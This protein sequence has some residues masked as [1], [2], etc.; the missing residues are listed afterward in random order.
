MFGIVSACN[1]CFNS[2]TDLTEFDFRFVL[3]CP[4]LPPLDT[5]AKIII[6]VLSPSPL[7]PQNKK[8]RVFWSIITIRLRGL[9]KWSDHSKRRQFVKELS[10]IGENPFDI[11]V[12]YKTTVGL[13]DTDYNG[14]L[15]NSSYAKNLDY[16]R[17]R[18]AVVCFP[19]VL[20]AKG[21]LGLGSSHFYF[22]KVTFS[23]FILFPVFPLMKIRTNMVK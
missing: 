11:C 22:I 21:W 5:G 19:S 7:F 4:P 1:P 16:A 15:S 14:H 10:P 9:L 18:A 13:T 23:F 6:S 2:W 17:M 3:F 8:V 20:E 12:T